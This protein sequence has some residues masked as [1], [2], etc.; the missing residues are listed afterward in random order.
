MADD[1]LG[2]RQRAAETKKRRTRERLINAI[3]D[4]YDPDQEDEADQPRT[5]EEVAEEAG[6]SLPTLYNHFDNRFALCHA[7]VTQLFDPLVRPIK[8]AIRANAYNPVDF[9]AE[10][11]S[12]VA[13]SA[14][15]LFAHRQL[16]AAYIQ[17]YF[18]TRQY[19]SSTVL[20]S[21][22]SEGLLSIMKVDN[23]EGR[24]VRFEWGSVGYHVN[25]FLL[26]ICERYSGWG[27]ETTA[28]SAASEMLRHML[29]VVDRSY[30]QS[31]FA[32]VEA[33]L[34]SILP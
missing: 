33:Q 5:L 1:D 20:T 29:T 21:F 9:R 34:E 16:L 14:S 28:H 23:E 27:L 6:V 4:L 25:A 31:D 30:S 19:E 8:M 11:V 18:E 15:L 32:T 3:I 17:A 13:R 2:P 7:A 22:M 10:I 24:P 12:Y 26:K